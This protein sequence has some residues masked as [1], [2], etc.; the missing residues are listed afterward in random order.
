MAGKAGRPAADQLRDRCVGINRQGK[1]CGWPPVAG[2][3]V[4]RHHVSSIEPERLTSLSDRLRSLTSVSLDRLE[5][6]LE[7]GK[8]ADAVRA[9]ALILGATLPRQVNIA[10][11]GEDGTNTG[12]TPAQIIRERLAAL[13]SR[14][15]AAAEGLSEPVP[16][17]QGSGVS[18]AGPA[19]QRL[20]EPRRALA[21]APAAVPVEMEPDDEIV[22]AEI[23]EDGYG[24]PPQHEPV[25]VDI[26]KI[27]YRRSVFNR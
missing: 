17:F 1:P 23:V 14:Q 18:M 19:G 16:G 8:D 27:A 20:S 15:D 26:Q 3:Q 21:P 12:P 4:C 7:H 25:A 9:A 10:V 24:L 22:D 6:V 13:R 2:L 11:V 5:A